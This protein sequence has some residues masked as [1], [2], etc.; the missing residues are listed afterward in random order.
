MTEDTDYVIKVVGT[1]S[2]FHAP[3]FEM[4]IYTDM[5]QIL[6]VNTGHERSCNVS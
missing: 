3:C 6:H 1:V 2:M 4:W 5:K